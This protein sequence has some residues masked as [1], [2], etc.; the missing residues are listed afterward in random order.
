MAQQQ[1]A[2]PATAAAPKGQQQSKKSKSK[3]PKGARTPNPK[4]KPGHK[5]LTAEQRARQQ[6]KALRNAASAAT[7]ESI[8]PRKSLVG[9]VGAALMPKLQADIAVQFAVTDEAT[10]ETEAAKRRRLRAEAIASGQQQANVVSGGLVSPMSTNVKRG[11]IMDDY[12]IKHR[13]DGLFVVLRYEGK[14]DGRRVCECAVGGRTWEDAARKRDRMISYRQ[15]ILAE[16]AERK[17]RKG[18]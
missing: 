1:K 12:E 8:T 13:P 5:R 3:R 7:L 6:V 9:A 2:N 17:A 14:D 16:R 10:E 11:D 15:R 4:V 18:R